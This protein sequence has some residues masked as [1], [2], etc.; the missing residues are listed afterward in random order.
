MLGVYDYTVV[1]T[2]L[3]AVSAALGIR[4]SS[5]GQFKAALA[6]LLVSGLCD[7]FDGVVARTKKNRTETEKKFGIQIDSLCDCISFGVQPAFI[8]YF[9]AR[10][11]NSDCKAI[12]YC[13]LA[14]GIMLIIG[15]VIRLAFFNVSEEERQN[16][17][18]SK[19]RNSY[20][21]LPVTNTSWIIPLFYLCINFV[22]GN[23]FCIIMTAITAL[24]AVLFIT[25]FKMFKPHGWILG[26]FGLGG[27]AIL[28]GIILS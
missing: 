1:L 6:C 14:A 21:G 26:I 17:E 28:I 5:Q 8:V 25:D 3:S 2:Y 15:A 11:M 23:P 20:R 7:M 12:E 27:L 19:L 24:C 4:F 22:T 16:S 9:M 18:G 10:Y 13:A